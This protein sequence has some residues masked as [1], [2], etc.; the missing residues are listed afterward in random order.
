MIPTSRAR[1]LAGLGALAATALV[2]SGCTPAAPEASTT[3]V[4]GG[5]LV[6]ASG[7]A[8]PECLDPHV[9]GNYPQAL[10]SSQFLEPLVSL[11]GEGGITPWLAETWT[12]SDDGLGLTLQLRQGVTFTDGTPF[13]A[14]A[15]VANIQHVQ[16]PA[17]L[18]S[19]GYLA[20]QAVADATAVDASTVQLTLSTPDSA[21]LESL[22]QPWLAMESPAGIARGT[23]ENC[24]QPIGTGPFLVERWDRQQSVSL[25]RNDDYSSPPADA[26]HSGPAYLE[27]I[28]WR[29][30]P[31]SASRYAALQSGEVD[32]I[33]NA[34]PDAIAS[35]TAAGTLGELD[36]PRPGASNRIE[37]N[38]GQA[39]F[40]DA[41]VREAFIRSADVDAGITA[42]FQG[43]AERSYSP[44]A[45][46]EP[47][48]V[49]DPDPFEI[50]VDRAGELLDAAGWSA[51]DADGIRTRD[52][53]RLT[54]RF[55]VSTNQSIPAEQSL[56]EQIQAT[57]KEVGFDVQLEPMDLGSW[58]EAL[59]DDAYELV[60][61]PYTKAGPDVLRILYDTSG[62]TPAP[63]GYFAN[64]A[65]VSVPEI[66]RA[67][68]EARSTTDLER[69]DALYAD[70]QRRVMEG[71]W[72]LPL[73]DQQNHFLL[74]A[75]VQGLRALPSVATP[76]LYDTWLAR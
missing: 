16:D 31:D 61:A 57:T 58:Y 27:R 33:D 19:T 56:F 32:V 72:I 73:Y 53:Q 25:I 70:V 13:D 64:H 43:T 69:R 35:A 40:D 36:A 55:P 46:T 52:G 65:K 9:G 60:S 7:D 17:T 39:P 30:L 10:V 42:L 63:S 66:D 44:L 75:D 5:T 2:L 8:E 48:G 47:A 34:Q 38:S 20:L 1:A 21:L 54:L 15:V 62:I 29:F 74:G 49:S 4:S 28:D 14:D 50:D 23:D 12:W 67:L 41:R 18:S 76:T 51:R 45:S 3:P 71:H 22:S 37:L 68:A 59:G 6:Y 11:D 26:E 24:A